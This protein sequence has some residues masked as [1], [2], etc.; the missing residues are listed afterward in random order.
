MNDIA[1]K[2][3]S[4]ENEYPDESPTEET[5]GEI[6]VDPDEVEDYPIDTDEAGKENTLIYEI[7]EIGN[8]RE[9]DLK[10]RKPEKMSL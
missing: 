7:I 1:V 3:A 6:G 5:D 9:S 2:I 10:L 4:N 8:I